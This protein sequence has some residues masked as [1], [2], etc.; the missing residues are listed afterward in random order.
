MVVSLRKSEFEVV[1]CKELSAAALNALEQL[2][3]TLEESEMRSQ[4]LSSVSS[5]EI[6]RI[7]THLEWI[8]DITGGE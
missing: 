5:E 4:R 1:S 8:I 7:I 6:K 3:Q 2:R